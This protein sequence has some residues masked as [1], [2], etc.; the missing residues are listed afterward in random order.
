VAGGGGG[1]AGRSGQSGKGTSIPGFLQTRLCPQ[2]IR[3]FRAHP[4]PVG[5]TAVSS[6]SPHSSIPL[7][8]A[9]AESEIE[10]VA[11]AARQPPSP[12]HPARVVQVYKLKRSASNRW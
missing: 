7:S 2:S 1:K 12:S 3:P 10:P 11:R 4:R 6:L 9:G 8:L 5:V